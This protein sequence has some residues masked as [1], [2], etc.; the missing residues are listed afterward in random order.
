M[1]GLFSNFFCR[2]C[3]LGF[4][5]SKCYREVWSGDGVR[6]CLGGKVGKVGFFGKRVV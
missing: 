1:F 3:V 5:G 4:E 6:I 2:E